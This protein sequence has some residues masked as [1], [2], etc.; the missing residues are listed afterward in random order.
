MS[1]EQYLLFC[2]DVSYSDLKDSS[3][4]RDI[5][6]CV[7]FI[8]N[9]VEQKKKILIYGDYDCDGIMSTSILYL[10]IKTNDYTPGFYIPFRES[11]GYGLTKNNIDRF[12]NLG[13]EVL[14][15]IDNGITLNDEVEY[16]KSLGLSVIIMDHHTVQ[17]SVPNADYILHPTYSS[18]SNINMCAGSVAFY[19]SVAYLGLIDDYLLTLSM[20][21]TISDLMELNDQNRVLVKLGLK[22]LNK[23]KY[24]NII[25]LLDHTELEITEEDVSMSI[26][27]KVNAI[28]RIINDNKLF[29]IVRY[30]ININDYE[31]INKTSTWIC[32]TNN[33]RKELVKTLCS[34]HQNIDENEHSIIIFDEDMKEGLVGLLAARFMEQYQ[35]PTVVLTSSQ[36]DPSIYK[37]SI[38]SKD[39]FDVNIILSSLSDILASY[40]G[41]QNAG[42]LSFKKENYELF[43]EKFE[44]AAKKH[45]FTAENK[46]YINISLTDINNENYK[47]IQT[48][49]PFGQGFSKPEFVLKDIATS[50]LTTTKDNKHIIARLNPTSSLIYFNYDRSLFNEKKI[51]LYGTF[52]P[53]CFKGFY[54]MQFIIF[55]F[56]N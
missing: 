13:Y 53:N 32:D 27:P 46:E 1:E 29:N 56:H 42:G 54:T 2:K 24:P 3:N 50:F 51:D 25:K 17:E 23:N 21:S 10:S 9:C 55:G 26:A 47:I 7:N 22:I 30:F 18:F 31:F 52:R 38:R 15:L 34:S 35:K 28:G 4:Y 44:N 45:P 20:I 14:I 40:G 43:K 16:A 49:A 41:H 11:D 8:K 36:E 48:L 37:G 12:K 39:G 33:Y 5:D 19:F 6:K